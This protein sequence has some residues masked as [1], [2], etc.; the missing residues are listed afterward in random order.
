MTPSGAL[1]A[2]IDAVVAASVRRRSRDGATTAELLDYL[3]AWDRRVDAARDDVA[4][5]RE[6][7]QEA[8][9]EA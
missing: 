5:L 3:R 6:L 2:D 4:A 7:L 9:D 8:R 1:I